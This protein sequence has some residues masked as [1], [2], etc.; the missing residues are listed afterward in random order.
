MPIQT[1]SD[2]FGFSGTILD[3]AEMYNIPHPQVFPVDKICSV[4]LTSL[5]AYQ[6]HFQKCKISLVEWPAAL[7]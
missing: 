7:K 4:P 6:L 3:S 1:S 5:Q 2:E